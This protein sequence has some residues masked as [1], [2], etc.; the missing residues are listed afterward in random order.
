MT[1]TRMS[2][3]S[4]RY[5]A[6]GAILLALA[7]LAGTGAGRAAAEEPGQA[8][9][10]HSL[11][12]NSDGRAPVVL[13]PVPLRAGLVILRARAAGSHVFTVDL[14]TAPPGASPLT[15]YTSS[16][17]VINSSARY[18]GAVA[19]L[20]PTDNDYYVIVSNSGAFQIDLEQ[21]VPE[22]VTPVQ[23]RTFTGERDGVTPVFAL[24]A[25]RYTVR[26]T[27]AATARLF[28]WLYLVDDLGGG[29]VFDSSDGRFLQQL[30]G[31]FDE[32]VTFTLRR[33]ALLFFYINAGSHDP[34]QDPPIWT[35]TVE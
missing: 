33:P 1:R 21:P 4:I 17:L 9:T 11:R 22:N 12:G 27:S 23:A 2:R 28:A 8:P 3:A 16:R 15:D 34:M 5:A 19:T 7:A 29:T 14:A 35:I 30:S 6:V 24:P 25:G 13:G 20:L 26:V 32:T 31:P 18:D 10:L